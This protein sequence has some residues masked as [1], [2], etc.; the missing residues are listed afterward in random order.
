MPAA[1]PSPT[2]AMVCTILFSK[3]LAPRKKNFKIAID[4]IAAGMDAE[5]VVPTFKARYALATANK[6]LKN[7]PRRIA[8]QVNSGRIVFEG[9]Y[10][11]NGLADTIP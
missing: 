9:I 11:L 4:I 6:R 2:V 3:M 7:R 10:G 5:T 1:S 8:R